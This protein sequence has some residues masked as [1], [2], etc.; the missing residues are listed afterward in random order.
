MKLLKLQVSKT[1]STS[2]QVT[3]QKNGRVRISAPL[4][5]KLNFK[6]GTKVS[7]Y[8]DEEDKKFIYV[9]EGDMYTIFR[10]VAGSN[11]GLYF[12]SPTMFKELGI[13]NLSLH[14]L[15]SKLM[16]LD[17]VLYLQLDISEILP[18]VIQ[19][20]PTNEKTEKPTDKPTTNRNR[21]SNSNKSQ[22]PTFL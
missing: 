16:M 8:T 9:T 13:E 5:E 21:N 10:H 22:E 2:D 4:A 20:L 3:V 7:V 12:G 15:T 19:P 11:S 14:T 1:R 18:K 17:K 6:E